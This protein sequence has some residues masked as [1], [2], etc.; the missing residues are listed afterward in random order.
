M[1][2][3]ILLCGVPAS[4]KTWVMSHLSGKYKCINNDDYIGKNRDQIITD[5]KNSAKESPVIVDCPF[6]E[7]ERREKLESVGLTVKPVFIVESPNVINNRYLSREGKP[8]TQSTLTRASTILD[9]AR[10]WEAP[11]GTSS[12]ILAMLR[13][14]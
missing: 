8:A 9:R 3:V 2:N 13:D 10:E 5:V 1:H 4:G 14:A 7:R 12:E 6:A 11:Y